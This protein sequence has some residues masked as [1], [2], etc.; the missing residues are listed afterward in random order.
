MR[1]L[2]VSR[3][4]QRHR[5][6]WDAPDVRNGGAERIMWETLVEWKGSTAEQARKNHERS[7]WCSSLRARQLPSCVGF[8]SA[9]RFFHEDYAC[10][11]RVLPAPESRSV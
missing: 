1:A 5:D 6:G 10:A 4:Q 11:V 2:E 9:F 7:H 8:G 3:W